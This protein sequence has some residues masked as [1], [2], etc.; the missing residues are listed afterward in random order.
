MWDCDY[1]RAVGEEIENRMGLDLHRRPNELHYAYFRP[2]MTSNTKMHSTTYRAKRLA[3]HGLM[4]SCRRLNVGAPSFV[5]RHFA[6]A[7]KV[8]NSLY[9]I[10]SDVL[11]TEIVVD[12][13]KNY[14]YG[15]EQVKRYPATTRA[16]LILRDGRGVYY[17][18]VKR[19]WPKNKA[20]KA[21][22]HFYQ[23]AVPLVEQLPENNWITVRYEAIVTEPA[24][25]LARICKFLE[26]PFEPE[27]TGGL[28]RTYHLAN[29][30]RFKYSD[31][32]NLALDER[33][34]TGLDEETMSF[35]Q[36]HGAE[37]NRVLGYT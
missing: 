5:E 32:R 1:W 10:I 34:K 33:W 14:L 23:R 21:W 36:E 3:L 17:S 15:C 22:K 16:L 9:Q 26:L 12:S 24:R 25:E 29:G 2:P 27:M 31:R 8:R 13:S 20:L 37:L 6:R 30:N 28:A 4:Y 18:H 7:A 35:F 11:D 19:G